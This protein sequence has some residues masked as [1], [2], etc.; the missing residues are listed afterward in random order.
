MANEYNQNR[1]L[2]DKKVAYFTKKYANPM[3]GLKNLKQFSE[4]GYWDFSCNEND[5]NPV[6]S[7][8][9]GLDYYDNTGDNIF[10]LFFSV[11]G[12]PYIPIQCKS[13]E[14]TRDFVQRVI[15][16]C[17]L[18]IEKEVLCIKNAMRLNLSNR[19]RGHF[20]KNNDK[21]TIIVYP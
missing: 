1:T 5:L 14:L 4:K 16:N 9:S 7:I 18:K 21:I 11:N 20:P 19:I 13:S 12:G 6:I 2:Y 15:N 3:E 10:T 17:G 8:S